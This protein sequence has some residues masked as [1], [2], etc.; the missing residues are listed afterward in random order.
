MKNSKIKNGL[1][2]GVNSPA[3]LKGFSLQELEGLAHEI[4]QRIINTVSKTGGHL[5]PSLGVVELTIALHYVFDTPKDKII[6]DVGHQAYAHK[7]I[8][9]RRDRFHTLRT[10]RGISGFPK[11]AES[12]YDTFDTGH[13]STS[14]SA[15][16]GVT[17]AKALKGEESKVVSVIG[18]GSMTAGMAFEGL[19]QAGHTEKDL[20]V[21][22]N[23][24]AMSIA[25]NVGAF[26]SF[27]SRKMTGRRFVN[28]K[29]ELE[30]FL[31]SLPGVGENILNLARKS[32]DSFITFFTPG[33]LFEAFRF[34]YIGPINGHRL[35]RLIGAFNNTLHLEG[36]VLV[37]VL[38]TK[39]KGY[40]PAEQDP[41]HY[42]GVGCFEIPTGSPPEV[43]SKPLPSYTDVFGKTM[44]ES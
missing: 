18:D 24:N 40:E 22:L 12:P 17:T 4:R 43:S 13:S 19:N 32:E 37:H 8:T 30:N 42:H 33:M 34:K 5:A 27:L 3:D 6:W 28:F 21:V 26:S 44:V 35:D 2:D 29:K 25:P 38:T 36:P 9:G 1:L 14:I 11:R 16:L 15:G 20:I 31:K 10:Y 23:D 7:L 41:C 39:G